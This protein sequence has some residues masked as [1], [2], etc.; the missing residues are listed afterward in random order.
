MSP[1][2]SPS[3]DIE[4]GSSALLS[5]ARGRRW[6]WVV[7]GFLL[8]TLCLMFL[9]GIALGSV[10]IPL[11]QV[12][13]VL[14]GGQAEKA[15]W[16]IIIETVRIPR[17]I[18]AVLAGA[19]LGLAG[20]QMQT[21]F[22]NP[23]AD[24]FILGVMA[25]ASFGVAVVVLLASSDP[26]SFTAGFGY[27]SSASMVIA[28][29]AGAGTVLALILLLSIHIRNYV[30]ILIIGLM[31][32]YAMGSLVTVMLASADARRIEL[33]VA[34]GFG[35]FRGVT[36][37][38]MQI[39]VP[40]V[41]LGII[42]SALL[43]KQLNALLLGESYARSMGLDVKRMRVLTMMGSSL[44][45]GVITAYCGPI[46]FLGVAIPHLARV[47][48]GTSDHRLLIPAVILL[49]GVLAIFAELVAQL[50]GLNAVL[51]L[52]AVTSLIGAPVVIIV[53]MRSRRGAFT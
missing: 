26:S 22:R 5:L 19:G 43:T 11:D 23:L 7:F 14:T 4:E 10:T 25:G 30:T 32:S 44:L 38:E 8:T 20:L 9:L 13:T 21:L 45:G 51:P 3:V 36:W 37:Q 29:V 27:L 1:E 18:T 28:A 15:S 35:S 40:V 24:P 41:A 53:L 39:F 2:R 52:N 42:F 34:W 50:P 31:F 6:H 47:L 49:G 33:F 12:F 16:G 46:A 48:L 17:S